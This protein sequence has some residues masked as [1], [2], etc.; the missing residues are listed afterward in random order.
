MPIA[1]KQYIPMNERCS[2]HQACLVRY[3]SIGASQTVMAMHTDVDSEHLDQ[4]HKRIMGFLVNVLFDPDINCDQV[5]PAS[6]I[7]FMPC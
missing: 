1:L 4:P 5:H 2:I 7:A 6:A 3:L